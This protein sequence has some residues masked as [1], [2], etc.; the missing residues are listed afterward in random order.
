ML[1]KIILNFKHLKFNISKS[2]FLRFLFVF[3]GFLKHKVLITGS[4]G[5]DF[6]WLTNIPDIGKVSFILHWHWSIRVCPKPL[7]FFFFG[8]TWGI[9]K[10]PGQ[11]SNP[12]WSCN[13][14]H[15]SSTTR[16]L[17]HHARAGIEPVLPQRQARS[18]T[19]CTTA[20]TP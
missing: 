17:T 13:L 3:K 9:W 15:I 10:F 8:H 4:E 5:L 7:S 6:C 1:D 2:S 18:L 11:E 19:H 14:Y 20:G 16:T 12:S